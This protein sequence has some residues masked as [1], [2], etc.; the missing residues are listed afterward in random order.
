M[1][2]VWSTAISALLLSSVCP[3]AFAK[4]SRLEDSAF[5]H[6]LYVASGRFLEGARGRYFLRGSKLVQDNAWEGLTGPHNED[7]VLSPY[8]LILSGCRR[9]SCDER[10]AILLGRSG[11]IEAIGLI[12]FVCGA[13]RTAVCVDRPPRVAVFLKHSPKSALF[14]RQIRD[15]ARSQEG[16]A[17][18]YDVVWVRGRAGR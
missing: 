10:S 15:W 14:L 2:A 7:K 4:P 9:H 6:K 18:P 1:K 13:R 8:G 16:Q 11:D 3:S 5:D 17:I 12:N